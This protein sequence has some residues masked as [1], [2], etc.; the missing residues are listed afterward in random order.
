MS[1]FSVPKSFD[2]D[3]GVEA[4]NKGRRVAEGDRQAFAVAAFGA[5]FDDATWHIELETRLRLMHRHHTGLKQHRGNADR[6][7]AGHRNIFR[8]LHDDGPR[9]A[10]LARRWN[11]EIDVPR[12]AAAWLADQHPSD[13]VVIALHRD[14]LVHHRAAR[15]RKNAAHD[16]IAD[17]TFGMTADNTNRGFRT[18]SCCFALSSAS[19]KLCR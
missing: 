13:M 16:N 9:D 19:G 15:R 5:D 3:V 7:G 10:I 11:H 1:T 17:F 4:V 2:L 12:D 14:H 6:V 18:H 8:R